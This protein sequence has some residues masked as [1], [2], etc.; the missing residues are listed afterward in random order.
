MPHEQNNSEYN[1][2]YFET[3]EEEMKNPEWT[4]EDRQVKDKPLTQSDIRHYRQFNMEG[5]TVEFKQ[6]EVYIDKEQ[7][8]IRKKLINI[9]KEAGYIHKRAHQIPYWKFKKAFTKYLLR[10]PVIFNNKKTHKHTFNLKNTPLHILG[11]D[12]LHR[13]Q[14]DTVLRIKILPIYIYNKN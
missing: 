14:I 12:K 10:N 13:R 1:T 5:I 4:C 8:E 7:S 3:Y 11:I 2:Q 6:G 9:L